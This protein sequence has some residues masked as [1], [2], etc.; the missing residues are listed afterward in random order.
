MSISECLAQVKE[1]FGE[2]REE[3]GLFQPSE[4]CLM[5]N[6][7][8]P[9]APLPK[10]G[11]RKWP[12]LVFLHGG[13]LQVGNPSHTERYWPE[14]L[15]APDGGNLNAV[16]VSVAY[17]LNIFGFLAGEGLKGNFGFWVSRDCISH[18]RKF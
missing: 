9:V 11:E 4:D 12:V 14:G 8:T 15:I 18:S 16:V 5:L 10:E 7:W 3:Y 1:N 17:R 2:G 6:I 13:W